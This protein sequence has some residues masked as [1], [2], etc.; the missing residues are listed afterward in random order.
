MKSEKEIKQFSDKLCQ[1]IILLS[2][3]CD[4]GTAPLHC[5]YRLVGL[6]STLVTGVGSHNHDWLNFSTSGD[7]ASCTDQLPNVLCL[8][9]AH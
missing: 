2:R 4:A 7:Y 1:N 9:F 8:H 5:P 3:S 6:R